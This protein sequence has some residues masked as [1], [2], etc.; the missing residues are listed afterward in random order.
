M[1]RCLDLT[2]R[3]I[4]ANPQLVLFLCAAGRAGNVVALEA[5]ESPHFVQGISDD[6][7]PALYDESLVD[8]SVKIR[9]E[10]AANV[11]CRLAREEGLLVG[12]SAGANVLAALELAE[13]CRTVVTV[14]PDRAERYLS[15]SQE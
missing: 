14:L 5:A 2:T 10:E 3:Q 15:L 1:V 4:C 8:E 13:R 11:T 7:V 12:T 6:L 9:S